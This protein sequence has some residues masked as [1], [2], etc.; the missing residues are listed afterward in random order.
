MMEL[1]LEGY[2]FD[3]KGHLWPDAVTGAI[4]VA[5]IV[6]DEFFAN[7]LD[8]SMP[9]LTSVFKEKERIRGEQIRAIAADAEGIALDPAEVYEGFKSYYDMIKMSPS[10][11]ALILSGV[12]SY[13]DFKM[14]GEEITEMEHEL[15]LIQHVQI[16]DGSRFLRIHPTIKIDDKYRRI[17]HS[18]CLD[19]SDFVIPSAAELKFSFAV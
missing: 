11:V 8:L 5:T 3:F 2:D 9:V 12:G 14:R 10:I 19:C 15:C 13:T 6:E 18:H 16:K 1:N 4:L 17:R 7:D